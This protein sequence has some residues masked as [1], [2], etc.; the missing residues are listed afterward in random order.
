MAQ[1]VT[2]TQQLLEILQAHRAEIRAHGV[3]RLGIFGSFARGE[4]KAASDVDVLVDFRPGSKSY[5]SFVA[6]AT[7]IEGLLGRPIDLLTRE[8]LSPYLGPRILA[9][10]RNVP[11]GHLSS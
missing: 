11:L 3:E 10:V 1:A 8:S 7:L 9:E 2:D 5:D 6:L 4:Q